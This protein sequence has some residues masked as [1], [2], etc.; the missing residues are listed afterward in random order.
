ML[1]QL[2][3]LRKQKKYPLKSIDQFQERNLPSD[4]TN[5]WL[6]DTGAVGV[7]WY[8]EG[9]LVGGWTPTFCSF[10]ISS[11]DALGVMKSWLAVFVTRLS[12]A[13]VF[14]FVSVSRAL[15]SETNCCALFWGTAVVVTV[16]EATELIVVGVGLLLIKLSTSADV[17][18]G[19]NEVNV[20]AK[21]GT[22]GMNGKGCGGL[23]VCEAGMVGTF[24]LV[25]NVPG[26]VNW[27]SNK[28][29]DG[30]WKKECQIFYLKNQLKL[31]Q[32]PAC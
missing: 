5:C 14:A 10:W 9:M 8:I 16:V 25:T 27:G 15:T 30:P 19:F 24:V 1:E 23:I 21:G 4:C 22:I 2:M 26:D 17:T 13:V 6:L 29:W 7:C 20:F 31:L 18:V 28:G 3:P 11:F 32:C 12:I